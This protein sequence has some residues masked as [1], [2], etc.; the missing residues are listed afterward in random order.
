MENTQP[1]GRAARIAAL[2]DAFRKGIGAPIE[3]SRTRSPTCA[4]AVVDAIEQSAQHELLTG[5]TPSA[6]DRPPNF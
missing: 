1:T 2:N 6:R 4:L 3:R 5:V